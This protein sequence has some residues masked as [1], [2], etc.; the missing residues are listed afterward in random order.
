M[1]ILAFVSGLAIVVL[2]AIVLALIY[3]GRSTVRD[4]SPQ[5]R[6][7]APPRPSQPDEEMLAQLAAAM[8]EYP[9]VSKVADIGHEVIGL[10]Q[11]GGPS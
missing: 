5:L 2:G 7:A 10:R 6:L 8:R 11:E 9:G 1:I 4:V 3:A